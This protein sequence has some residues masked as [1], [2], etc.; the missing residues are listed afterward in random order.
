MSKRRGGAASKKRGR[1]SGG[2]KSARKSTRKS[3][4]KSSRKTTRKS[5]RKKSSR[6]QSPVARVKR[7]ATEVV[8]QA[9]EGVKKLGDFTGD[10]VERLT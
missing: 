1:K 4:R 5:S 3:A 6:K 10:L 8:K 7:V 9:E 2:A